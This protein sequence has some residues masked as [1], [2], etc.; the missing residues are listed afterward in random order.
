MNRLLNG[1]ILQV[2]EKSIPKELSKFCGQRKLVET[3]L[4]W[5]HDYAQFISKNFSLLDF[6]V[7]VSFF[8]LEL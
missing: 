7:F 8:L 3:S 4:P 6:E 2:L 1:M 5:L